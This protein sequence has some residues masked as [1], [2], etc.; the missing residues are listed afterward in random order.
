MKPVRFAL[1]STSTTISYL[2]FNIIIIRT[3]LRCTSF[4][5]GLVRIGTT[6]YTCVHTYNQSTDIIMYLR[7]RT[8]LH[9]VFHSKTFVLCT[10]TQKETTYAYVQSSL[11]S[12]RDIKSIQSQS[13]VRSMAGHH[14]SHSLHHCFTLSFTVSTEPFSFATSSPRIFESQILNITNC[15]TNKMCHILVQLYLSLYLLEICR[16]G[17]IIGM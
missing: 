7:E 1:S 8:I 14:T 10:T 15:T 3:L 16:Q 9:G 2:P 11:V 6:T 13:I 12:T 5:H 4:M 17:I